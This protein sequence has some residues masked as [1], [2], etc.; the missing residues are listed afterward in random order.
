MNGTPP[1]SYLLSHYLSIAA[2]NSLHPSVVFVVIVDVARFCLLY[3]FRLSFSFARNLVPVSR[4]SLTVTAALTVAP[5]LG[6]LVT[7]FLERDPPVRAMMKTAVTVTVLDSGT[8]V[9]CLAICLS[10]RVCCYV[11]EKCRYYG[12]LI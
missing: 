4:I 12:C 5:A 2:G 9:V 8:C 7:L 10:V 3:R 1:P 11:S 6:S